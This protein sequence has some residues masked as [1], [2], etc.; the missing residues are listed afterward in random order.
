MH[1]GKQEVTEVVCFVTNGQVHAYPTPLNRYGVFFSTMSANVWNVNA[2][3][4]SDAIIH[5]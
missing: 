2:Y 1:E 3:L 4:F 5:R